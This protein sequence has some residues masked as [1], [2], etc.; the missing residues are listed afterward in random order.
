MEAFFQAEH[1]VCD[2]W[3]PVLRTRSETR[4]LHLI[5]YLCTKSMFVLAVKFVI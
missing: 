3:E 4:T 2:W 5:L 1:D